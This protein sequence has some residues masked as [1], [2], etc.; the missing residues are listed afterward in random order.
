VSCSSAETQESMIC[1][2]GGRACDFFWVCLSEGE[3]VEYAMA[4]GCGA[5]GL[6]IARCMGMEDSGKVGD[7]SVD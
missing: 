4:S 1:S 6:L 7:D 2:D 3:C 5:M